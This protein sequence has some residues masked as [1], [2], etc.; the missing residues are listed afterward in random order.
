MD[1]DTH[2]EPSQHKTTIL[3]SSTLHTRLTQLA[4]QR[5]VRMGH[6][7]R[8]AVQVQY[9]LVDREERVKALRALGELSLPVGSPQ[10][11]KVESNP[12]GDDPLP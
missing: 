11:M 9:G 7:I 4:R 1:M 3:L 10:A 8:T 5:G 2:M 6:L 12:F